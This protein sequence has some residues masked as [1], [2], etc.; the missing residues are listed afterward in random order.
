MT[1]GGFQGLRSPSSFGCYVTKFEP[2]SAV[3]LIAQ[4]ELT[5]ERGFNFTVWFRGI[6]ISSSSSGHEVS[7]LVTKTFMASSKLG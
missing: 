3:K 4:G 2:F 1:L 7:A 5:F 6:I